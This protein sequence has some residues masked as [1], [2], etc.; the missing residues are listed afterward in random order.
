MKIAIAG[1]MASGKTTLADKL[2]AELEDLDFRVA[3]HSLATKVKEIGRDLFGMKEK[4]RRLLQKIGMKMR[5]INPDVWIDYLN[6]T[7][8]QDLLEDKYDVAIV[9]DVRFVNEAKVFKQDGW[10]IIRLN[11]EEEL[12][13]ARLQR[14]YPDWE[15]HWDSRGDPSETEVIEI[16]TDFLWLD[17]DVDDSDSVWNTVLQEIQQI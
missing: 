10:L 8:N 6:R 15:V 11:I 1:K 2:Q 5:E 3:R 13:K 17:I 9:D 7:I 14:T 12:Q 4:D 16:A